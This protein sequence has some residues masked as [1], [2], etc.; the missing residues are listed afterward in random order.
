MDARDASRADR[1]GRVRKRAD[2]LKVIGQLGLG[3]VEGAGLNSG[4]L[5]YRDL[6]IGMPRLPYPIA[7]AKT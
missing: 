2:V 1:V 6:A 4:S 5:R 7:G 3:R